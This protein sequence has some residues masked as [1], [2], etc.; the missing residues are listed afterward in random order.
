MSNLL[1]GR[2][3]LHELLGEGGMAVVYRATQVN[4]AREVAVKFIK[5]GT[6]TTG[7]KLAARFEREAKAI[8]QLNHPNITQV[9]DFDV[10]EDGRYYLVM[11]RLHGLDLAEFLEIYEML[12]FHDVLLVMNGICAALRYAHEYEIVHRDIKPSNIFLTTDKQIKLMD[13]GLAKLATD[14][15]LTGS[16][17]TLGTPKYF[18]PE[19]AE[20]QPLDQRSDIYSLGIVFYQLLTG[21]LPFDGNSVVNLILQHLTAPIPD[22]LEINAEL[23]SL[24]TEMVFKMLAKKPE[25]RYPDIESVQADLAILATSD[26]DAGMLASIN[27]ANAIPHRKTSQPLAT[28]SRATAH[29][30]PASRPATSTLSTSVLQQTVRLPL[31]LIIA[32]MVVLI[33]GAA[34]LVS[35]LSNGNDNETP[36]AADQFVPDVM[37]A[38]TGEYLILVA[39]WG[40]EDQTLG[41]RIADTL[42]ASDSVGLSPHITVRIELIDYQIQNMDE[43][44]RIANTVDAH[45]VV[46]GIRD[47]VGVEIIFEDVYAEP[48]SVS[49]MRF[50]VPNND[51]YAEILTQDMP[52]TVRF[53]LSSMLLHHFVRVQDIDGFAGFGFNPSGAS[54]LR[55]I[56]PTDLDQHMI[57]LF[58]RSDFDDPN[59][60]IETLTEAIRLAP[61]DPTL[62]FMR[63]YFEGFYVGDLESSQAD[64][65]TLRELVGDNNFSLWAQMNIDL[66][67]EDYPNIIVL[68]DQLDTSI[69][70]YGIPFSYRQLA[71][72]STG[73]FAQ[74]QIEVQGDITEQDVFGLPIWDLALAMS[75]EAQGDTAALEPVASRVRTNRN[76][77]ATNSFISSISALPAGFYLIGGYL[78]ELNGDTL[79]AVLTYQQGLTVSPQN[80]LIHWRLGILSEQ[81]R[82]IEDAYEFYDNARRFAPSPVPIITY[83][84][85]NLVN[86]HG[87]E[88]A[89]QDAP[90]AC[91]LLA[92]AAEETNIDED[93]YQQ[94]LA[95]INDKQAEWDC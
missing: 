62:I 54:E 22:P 45:L 75:Y 79:V 38:T 85:A 82:D 41:R 43:A 21:Q 70:G 5:S 84:Q 40:D 67:E 52:Q 31:P 30:Q 7:N 63:S 42:A 2:Y 34:L 8:A 68:S 77:E 17:A 87:D 28:I 55:V 44:I 94:L 92:I 81:S 91:E 76:L 27:I 58:V 78:S 48:R 4:L 37:P 53:Y 57:D 59:L 39:D 61:G 71:F 51:Q 15:N 23:P 74:I 3:E 72:A 69:P 18:S 14:S 46:W 36:A 25:D 89:L 86:A 13:F 9:Y 65:N 32:V 26:N 64:V 10:S 56:A 83:Q 93:F 49:T 60:V 73:N 29:S 11:E 88:E 66:N 33:G 95:E 47:D 12:P 50:I 19:Q 90:P 24:A 20:G 80:Y 16:G 1:N 6:S 35:S